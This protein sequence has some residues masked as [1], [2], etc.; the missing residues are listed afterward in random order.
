ME[1]IDI[2]QIELLENVKIINTTAPIVV[3]C[4]PPDIYPPPPPSTPC[5][6]RWADPNSSNIANDIIDNI[7]IS[8]IPNVGSL[9]TVDLTNISNC[10]LPLDCLGKPQPN[11][12]RQSTDYNS[13]S[14]IIINFSNPV[15]DL[16]MALYS[17]SA[18]NS[19][20]TILLSSTA[21]IYCNTIDTSI[22][23]CGA[24]PYNNPIQM[25]DSTTITGEEAYG[26]VKFPGA[27]SSL[28]LTKTTGSDFPA[29]KL[30]I[31]C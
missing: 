27:N 29:F 20:G 17:F 8:Y 23:G 25:P 24:S 11:L 16:A 19:L 28:T 30:G 6:I 7:V 31:F 21:E 4:C 2:K 1:Y 18:I 3:T 5:F 15:V 10:Y 26:I 13:L 14:S 22:P 12:I 9:P